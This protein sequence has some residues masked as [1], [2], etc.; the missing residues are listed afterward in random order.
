MAP[1][2]FDTLNLVSTPVWI[3]RTGAQELLFAN[4]AASEISAE[5]DL[6]HLRQGPFSVH[7][8]LHLDAYLPALTRKEVVVEIW[9]IQKEGKDYPL[10]CRLTLKQSDGPA[11][12]IIVEGI[13]TS[14]V[15]NP[16]RHTGFRSGCNRKD[17]CIGQSLYEQLFQNNGV[18]MLL[19]DPVA[20]GRIVDA[21]LA[22]TRLYGYSRD[23]I[24]QKHTWEIN[25][26]GRDVLP[27][28]HEV[29]RLPGGHKPLNF[30]H[31]L[32]D[33]TTRHVQTYAGPMELDGKRLML[34]IVH[35]TSEQKRLEEELQKAALQDPLTGL[36]NRRHLIRLAH[37]A[38]AQMQRYGQIFSVMLIDVDHFKSINDIYGHHKGDEVLIL[39]ART[40]ESRIRE[41]D[42]VCR[43]GGEE[44]VIF[45]P[46]TNREGGLL[47][48]ESIRQ[49][50]EHLRQTDFPNLT[51]SI[52][53][54]QCQASEDTDI[55]F[56]RVDKALYRAKALG[57]NRV[58]SA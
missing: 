23:E 53:V 55:L 28:M 40:L 4:T 51:V 42:S 1:S 16:E 25:T 57:R 38:H 37:G 3:V 15:S 33:G 31:K 2:P 19:I 13:G 48:A 24:C 8:H 41:S 27:V 17:D 22:A 6:L 5:L 49:H 35:D 34:G 7:A 10:S 29:A 32:A 46:Q 54:A 12:L 50:I 43:W 39:L 47:M 44:F 11:P 14:G 9:T 45:L 18:P 20:D 58:E 26:M 30:I 56:R 52:G 36:W 21:N